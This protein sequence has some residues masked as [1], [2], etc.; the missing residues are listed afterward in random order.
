MAEDLSVGTL[1]FIIIR[2]ICYIRNTFTIQA[3]QRLVVRAAVNLTIAEFK[4]R[5]AETVLALES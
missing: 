2:T 1:E 5:N 3:F 4:I